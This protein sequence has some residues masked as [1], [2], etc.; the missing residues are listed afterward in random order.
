MRHNV[1]ANCC[2]SV[3]VAFK[4]HL[5][6]KLGWPGLAMIDRLARA[7]SGATQRCTIAPS[8]F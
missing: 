8:R 4:V 2:H 7:G 1:T 6:K 3:V 5:Y